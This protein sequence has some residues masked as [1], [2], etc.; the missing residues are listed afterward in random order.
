M[1]KYYRTTSR[2]FVRKWDKVYIMKRYK[3]WKDYYSLI[4]GWI[5]EWETPLDAF[6]R[7]VFEEASLKIQSIKHLWEIENE[8]KWKLYK[9]Y[10]FESTTKDDYK[11][12]TWPEFQKFDENNRYE[13]ILLN[14]SDIKNL[15]FVPENAWVEKYIL[16]FVEKYK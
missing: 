7:E 5:D 3:D 6:E 13:I 16:D 8:Y 14:I 9:H 2:G 4:W 1:K 15:N 11:L 10:I 12:W